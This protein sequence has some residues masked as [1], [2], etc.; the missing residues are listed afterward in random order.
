MPETTSP[1]A[2]S[3]GRVRGGAVA[4]VLVVAAALAGCTAGDGAGAGAAGETAVQPGATVTQTLSPTPTPTPTEDAVP[5]AAFDPVLQLLVERLNAA[6]D[7]AASKYFSG[8]PVTDE[9][10]EQAVLQAAADAATAAGADP[11]YVRDVFADQIAASKA[12]QEAL[13]AEWRSGTTPPPTEA[14]DLAT[15]VRPVLDRITTELV[16]ALAAAEQYRAAD[17]CGTAVGSSV[18]TTSPGLAPS[19]S[20]ALAIA[21]ASLCD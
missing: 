4:A 13:L 6:P 5:T 16:P 17:G 12:V 9:A 20:G 2:A 7:V 3:V 14:P 18:A 8:Q 10:R 11:D 1:A 21:T 15:Q 19:A